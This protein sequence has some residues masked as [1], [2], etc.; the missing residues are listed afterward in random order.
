M[1]S[2]GFTNPSS[3]AD[4]Q[5]R[6]DHHDAVAARIAPPHAPA[7]F[8]VTEADAAAI[9]A[10]YEQRGEFSAAIELRRRFP[11]ITDNAQAMEC[12][13]TIAGWQAAAAGAAAAQGQVAPQEVAET[14]ANT[15][16]GCGCSSS[17]PP[18]RRPSRSGSST[19][20]AEGRIN[21]LL[22]DPLLLQKSGRPASTRQ[23]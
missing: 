2:L 15:L 1:L 13:R 14:A 12:A 8:V 5:C 11:G 10:V 3:V 22:S 4:R 7:M 21:T 20:A 19:P 9:R 16:S 23:G 17:G 18:T 6:H